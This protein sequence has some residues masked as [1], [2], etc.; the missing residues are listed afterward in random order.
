MPTDD[1]PLG[2]HDFES[3]IPEG[4]YGAGPV[5]V[6]DAGT[7]HPLVDKPIGEQIRDG[8][9]AFWLEGHKL[10]GGFALTRISGGKKPRW[11]LVKMDDAKADRRRSP[12]SALPE[13]VLTG[14]TIEDLLRRGA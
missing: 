4:E 11:L 6:W 7:Y 14:R 1:H 5:I 2:C 13:S 9:V 8:H 10:D 3:V 12:V